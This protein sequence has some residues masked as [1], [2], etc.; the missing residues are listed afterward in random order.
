M[1]ENADNCEHPWNSFWA[2]PYTHFK[3]KLKNSSILA[4]LN[5]T[6]CI[7]PDTLRHAN[8][9]I[10]CVVPY[11]VKLRGDKIKKWEIKG[12]EIKEIFQKNAF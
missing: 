5:I 11:Y 7:K 6:V 3:T 12:V 9:Q 10:E 4:N 8:P 1:L 2:C